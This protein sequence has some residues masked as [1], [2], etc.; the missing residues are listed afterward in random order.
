MNVKT[1]LKAEVAASEALPWWKGATI[2]QI[3]PRSFMDANGDGI[4]DLPGITRRLPHIANLGVDAIWVSPFFKSPMKDFGYDVSDYRAVDPI[5]GNL[6]DFDALVARAHELGLKVLIDQV[7]SHTS[8]EHNWFNESRS[9]RD[10]PKADWYVWADAKPDGSPPS[11][12]Q[13]VFGGP[14]WTWDARRG[15]YY[16]HNFLASQPQLNLHNKDAQDAVLGVMRFWLE[17]GVD[18]F[19]IDA[20]NFAMHD[21]QLRDNPPAPENGKPRTRPFDFQLKQYNQSHSD[22]P[23]FI[24]RIRSLTDEFDGIFTVAEVGGDDAV[25][26][27]RLFT[28]GE[29][30]LNSAYSF[31]FLYADKLRPELVCASL[32]EWPDEE[33]L[34]WPSWAFENHDAPRAL[35]RWCTPEERD[36][37]ARLKTL[38]LMCLR[39][40]AIIYY[41]EELGLTQVDIPFEQLQDPE[42]IANWP[43]TLSRDGARTPMPWNASACAGFGSTD[44]WLPVGEDNRART[45]EAQEADKNSLLHFTREAIALRKAHPALHHGKVAECRAEGDLLVIVREAG[46]QRIECRFN[47]G[48]APIACSDCQGEV[49]MAINGAS[50]RELPAHAAIITEISA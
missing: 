6:D 4:G 50:H 30:H 33:R 9:S 49:L 34:G 24:E 3:Y 42:A 12:W 8:D 15:Q 44:P 31:N 2:Y 26:E 7:Y 23:A 21:P 22:I 27:M 45:V 13:S 35:S 17:R 29:T 37:F 10:N 5:F 36:D 25:R 18:G 32:A 48:S 28:D 1:D 14:A 19:R 47:L 40:N 46:A 11:N 41:G 16:L 20:L 39:G 43:L 38:L